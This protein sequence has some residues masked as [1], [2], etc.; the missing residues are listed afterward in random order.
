VVGDS[1]AELYAGT[2]DELA[3][4]KYQREDFGAVLRAK[5][6]KML[7]L[8]D[9]IRQRERLLRSLREEGTRQV[10]EARAAIARQCDALQGSLKRWESILIDLNRRFT[11]AERLEAEVHRQRAALE[12][13]QDLV[14]RVDL[15]G[16]LE[17]E[18]LK[19]VDEPAVEPLSR[20][21][22]RRTV[23]AV[24]GGL[25]SGVLLVV[26]LEARRRRFIDRPTSL[27]SLTDR[28][29]VE[30]APP[31]EPT[32]VG[33]DAL[34]VRADTPSWEGFR[35]WRAA[36]KGSTAAQVLVLLGVQQADGMAT[37]LPE[38]GYALAST[39]ER[40]L[41]IDADLRQPTLHRWCTGEQSLGLAQ[42]LEEGTDWRS[43]IQPGGVTGLALLPAGRG[44]RTPG[45]LVV[46]SAW[47]GLLAKARGDFDRVLVNVPALDAGAEVF[48]LTPGTD[49]VFLALRKGRM[50]VDAAEAVV[51]R[52][53]RARLRVAGWILV[54]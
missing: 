19:V 4:L 29:C 18:L 33:W 27:R 10:E 32:P 23:A 5:H 50:P 2:R 42:V 53:S 8:E 52:L 21:R 46:G 22:P 11:E 37:L 54:G 13:V 48:A 31:P 1:T 36:L 40:V 30:L 3:V 45:D 26:L 34:R 41:L 44:H 35:E 28:W 38:L 39:G 7:A 25:L 51:A 12:G 6:P 17:S 47:S 9:A 20:W 43:V 15:G 24:P 16:R 14:Q 49:G